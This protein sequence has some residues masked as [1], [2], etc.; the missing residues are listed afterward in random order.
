MDYHGQTIPVLD[1]RRAVGVPT[2]DVADADVYVVVVYR[3]R[4]FLGLM[5]DEL[6]GQEEVVVK[7]LGRFVDRVP[8]ISG[9][10]IMGDGSIAL[11]L[12]VLSI[13]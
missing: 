5:V 4:K 11:I 9:A 10:T 2:S 1:L 8:G 13:V 6:L 3:G 12:D 7:P